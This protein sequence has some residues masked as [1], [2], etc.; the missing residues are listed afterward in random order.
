VSAVR[1]VGVVDG[2]RRA[3]GDAFRGKRRRQL[4]PFGQMRKRRAG[5]N[6][7]GSRKGTVER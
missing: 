6:G 1:E 5:S 4:A 2:G 7:G 3:V